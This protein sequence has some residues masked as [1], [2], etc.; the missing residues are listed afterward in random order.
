MRKP[1]SR[2]V[3]R[4]TTGGTA[5]RRMYHGKRVVQIPSERDRMIERIRELEELIKRVAENE[6]TQ[7]EWTK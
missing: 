7:S 4:I 5:P 1:S 3:P 6:Y 2:K